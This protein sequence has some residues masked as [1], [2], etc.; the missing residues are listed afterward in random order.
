MKN[1]PKNDPKQPKCLY[2]T[3]LQSDAMFK[4]HCYKNSCKFAP[5]LSMSWYIFVQNRNYD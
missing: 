4:T 5:V 1:T 2:L 3:D